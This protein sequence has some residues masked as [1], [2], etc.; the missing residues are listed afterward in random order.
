VADAVRND[1]LDIRPGAAYATDNYSL[2]AWALVAI[3]VL[4]ALADRSGLLRLLSSLGAALVL[5][6][7]YRAAGVTPRRLKQLSIVTG[8]V[9]V[10]LTVT[11]FSDDRIIA[12]LS[13]VVIAVLLG[14]GP[15]VLVRRIFEQPV[16][17]AAHVLAAVVAYAQIALFFSYLFGALELLIDTPF[18]NQE[19][20]GS[21]AFLYF[22]VVTIT[23]LGYGDLTPATDIGRSMVMIET[24]LG[25]IFLV[26]L[27][28]R[29]VSVLGVEATHRRS[30]APDPADGEREET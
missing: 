25:Q 19:G 3:V 18:F 8:L 11:S 21:F 10:V 27:V 16:I 13:L 1:E 5:F 29:L 12:G 9:V 15:G 7:T 24:V 6:G 30:S 28:A 17:R 2:V 22:S 23:T 4:G 14:G 26:V 20:Y